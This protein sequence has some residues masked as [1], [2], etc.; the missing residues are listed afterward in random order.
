[1]PYTGPK[2]Y[3]LSARFLHAASRKFDQSGQGTPDA[4][5]R[6]RQMFPSQTCQNA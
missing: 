3:L 4:E 6:Q 1:M 2:P 5:Y